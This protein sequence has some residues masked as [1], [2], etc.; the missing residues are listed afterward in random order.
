MELLRQG[1]EWW[2]RA[3]PAGSKA[4]S[5]ALLPAGI[6]L[7]SALSKG[8][9]HKLHPCSSYQWAFSAVFPMRKTHRDFY[10]SLMALSLSEWPLAEPPLCQKSCWALLRE[11]RFYFSFLLHSEHVFFPCQWVPPSSHRV[12]IQKNVFP[13]NNGSGI[14]TSSVWHPVG[15]VAQQ[16]WGSNIN[17]GY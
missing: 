13:S 2:V 12:Q 1:R 9:E 3:I 15:I 16:W 17:A 8:Q 6:L 14:K 4:R 7:C 11:G 10:G 5:S